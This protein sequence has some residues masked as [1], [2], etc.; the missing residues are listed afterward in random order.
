[1]EQMRKTLDKLICYKQGIQTS[2]D[3]DLRV[4]FLPLHLLYKT[5]LSYSRHK[6]FLHWL[7]HIPVYIDPKYK[8]NTKLQYFKVG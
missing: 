7:L 4:R 2:S 8:K 5:H 6:T 3:G 1:M